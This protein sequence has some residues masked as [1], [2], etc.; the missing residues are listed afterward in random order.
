[1]TDNI[2]EVYFDTILLDLNATSANQ[3]YKKL[4]NH[5]SNIIGE[6]EKFLFDTIME[7]EENKNSGIG[8][9][10]AVGH[11]RLPRL[12]R[13]IIVYSKTAHP[14]DFKAA[15]EEL[16]NM[17]ILV[18]SPEFEGVKHLQRLA[19]ITRFF[20]DKETRVALQNSDDF[21]SIRAIV[22]QVNERKKAA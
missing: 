22:K 9:G 4:S 1:M 21:N 7:N 11:A 12:T 8:N 3:I 16:V 20:S 6:S 15:D 17:V 13:P 10:V 19:T 2:H 5:I 18:L 14:I